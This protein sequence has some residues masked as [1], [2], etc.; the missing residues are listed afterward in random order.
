MLYA[1]EFAGLALTALWIYCIIEVL[2]TPESEIRNL[3]K[4]VWL[5]LVLIF[6]FIGSIAWLIAGRSTRRH[7]PRSTAPWPSTRTAGFP[8]YERPHRQ[9]APDDDPEFLRRL[10]QVDQEH[11]EVLRKWEAD[12]RRREEELRKRSEP[13][14]S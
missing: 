5:F 2:F 1:E 3:P 7:A 9:S 8:E 11:T 12:L 4:L 14:E 13:E 6:S 10:S